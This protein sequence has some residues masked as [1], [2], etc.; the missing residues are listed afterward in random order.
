MF[1]DVTDAG[2]S[3]L[4]TGFFDDVDIFRDGYIMVKMRTDQIKKAQRIIAV[5]KGT[6]SGEAARIIAAFAV[7]MRSG[8]PCEA[9]LE[10]VD[11]KTYFVKIYEAENA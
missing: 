2:M 6:D 4:K 8:V 7:S 11:G 3:L 10:H 5:P 1:K 9:S